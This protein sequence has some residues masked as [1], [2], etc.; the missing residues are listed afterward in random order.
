MK[1]DMETTLALT[2]V[3]SLKA[4]APDMAWAP[5]QAYHELADVPVREINLLESIEHNLAQLEDLQARLRFMVR[6]VKYLMKV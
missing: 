6:E 2:P 1:Q 5:T 3:T 4:Q